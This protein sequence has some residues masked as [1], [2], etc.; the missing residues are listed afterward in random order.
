[1][2]GLLLVITAVL[3]LLLS[4]AAFACTDIQL[5][6]KDG[7]VLVGR[8]LEW[9]GVLKNAADG[10]SHIY[11]QFDFALRAWP[12]GNKIT[13]LKPDGTKGAS[14]SAKYAYFGFVGNKTSADVSDGQN[15][16]GLS[17]EMLYFP[18]YAEYQDVKPGDTNVIATDDFG[19]WLL[20]NFDSV[21]DIKR[22][23]PKMI[24]WGKPNAA[25]ANQIP[26]FHF[27]VH[28]KNGKSIIIE[29]V[30]KQLHIYDNTALVLTNSPDYAWMTSNLSNYINLSPDNV[31]RTFGA[32]KPFGQGTGMIGIPWRLHPSFA[33][34]KGRLPCFLRKTTGYGNGRRPLC[35]SYTEQRRH[36]FWFCEGEDTRWK[37]YPG[38]YDVEGC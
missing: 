20:G 11:S 4:Q 31:V 25:M 18:G 26:Q 19:S 38:L 35:Y 15:S 23:L 37:L 24:V 32:L 27:V 36:T 34:C 29:Y 2:K 3:V 13:S 21:D 17:L 10:T 22:Q 14:W 28:D 33:V 7:T 9:E 1:M 5:T 6:A 30:K 8:T 12:L 16:A